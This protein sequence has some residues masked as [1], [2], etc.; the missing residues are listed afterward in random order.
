MAAEATSH[1]L[2]R[3][4]IGSIDASSSCSSIKQD[5]AFKLVHLAS[6]CFLL[7]SEPKFWQLTAVFNAFYRLYLEIIIFVTN[8]VDKFSCV[9]W[10]MLNIT[11]H[12]ITTLLVFNYPEFQEFLF[13]TL[14]SRMFG[15]KSVG[16][17]YIKHLTSQGVGGRGAFAGF[18]LQECNC[19]CIL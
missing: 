11:I 5:L 14:Q 1:T 12:C 7:S 18:I 4:S 13:N 10:Q 17:R 16:T 3:R 19:C 2:L 8:P 9:T 6:F 15:V